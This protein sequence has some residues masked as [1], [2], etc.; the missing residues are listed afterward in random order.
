M[1]QLMIEDYPLNYKGGELKVVGRVTDKVPGELGH[2]SSMMV[3][4]NNGM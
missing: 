4:Q 2:Q 3:L 1:M